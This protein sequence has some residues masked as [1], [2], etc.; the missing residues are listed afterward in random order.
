MSCYPMGFFKSEKLDTPLVSSADIEAFMASKK[1]VECEGFKARIQES[2]CAVNYRKAIENSRTLE[3]SINSTY[4]K[5][6]LGCKTGQK[7]SAGKKINTYTCSE[8][9]RDL[10]EKRNKTGVCSICRGR[11]GRWGKAKAKVSA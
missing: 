8:C 11:R 5:P 10:G 3:T 1:Y 7:L 6:C 9:G 4:R 2:A